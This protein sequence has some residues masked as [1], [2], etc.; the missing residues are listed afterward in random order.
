MVRCV[1]AC[2]PSA[3]A[4][5]DNAVCPFTITVQVVAGWNNGSITVR[6]GESGEMIFK[7]SLGAGIAGL[8][9]SDYR[10]TGSPDILAVSTS[11]FLNI[12]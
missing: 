4:L 2:L 5:F 6:H 10:L 1:F 7:D 11:T 3:C 9:A 12:K 8:V